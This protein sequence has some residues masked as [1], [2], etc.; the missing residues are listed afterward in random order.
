MTQNT[1]HFRWLGCSDSW[2]EVSQERIEG[3]WIGAKA[4]STELL[5]KEVHSHKGKVINTR[6]QK[7]W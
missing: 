3:R 6:N 1:V 7:V 4:T 2:Q 5:V